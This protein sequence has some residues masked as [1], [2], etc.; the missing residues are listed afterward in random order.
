MHGRRLL[1]EMAHLSGKTLAHLE[2]LSV[3]GRECVVEATQR[4]TRAVVKNG[5]QLMLA[6]S[7]VEMWRDKLRCVPDCDRGTDW[8]QSLRMMPHNR[9]LAL[10]YC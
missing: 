8:R 1:Y 4:D 3:S 6:T 5:K 10:R 2:H 7:N 9:H